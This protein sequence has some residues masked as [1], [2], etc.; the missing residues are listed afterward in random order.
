MFDLN[1]FVWLEAFMINLHTYFSHSSKHHL[2]FQKLSIIME[3]KGNKI[4]KNVKMWWIFMLN[5]LKKIMS[6]YKPFLAIMQVNQMFIQMA[7]VNVN[8][9]FQCF[10]WFQVF[11]CYHVIWFWWAYSNFDNG[12]RGFEEWQ[13]INKPQIFLLYFILNYWDLAHKDH[14]TAAC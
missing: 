1:F 10:L 12:W 9:P 5:P 8:K 7:K 3:T 2:K 13:M 6:K 14:I 11:H 4:L